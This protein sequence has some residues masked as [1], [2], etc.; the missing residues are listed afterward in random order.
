M[1]DIIL[2]GIT[3]VGKT[4]I[5]RELATVL[6]KKFID[7]DKNIE[8]SCG[9]DIPT[10]FSI[11]GELGFRKRET[12]ELIKSLHNE[13]DYVLSLGGGVL[14]IDENRKILLSCNKQVIV[15]LYA[16][17][18]VLVE[19]LTKST[20]KRPL[21]QQTDLIKKITELYE[22]RKERYKEVADFTINT[23]EI[24]PDQTVNQIIKQISKLK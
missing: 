19:R 2:V 13:T 1:P 9:V 8:L 23:S 4:T 6:G 7:L 18:R 12:N 20:N 24:R 16:E 21:L 22:S 11:E 10:I 3:G 17:I 15:Q 5:G 14:T